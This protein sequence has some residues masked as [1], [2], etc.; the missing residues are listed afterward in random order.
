MK[1]I[2]KIGLCV[3]IGSSA[4]LSGADQMHR[5]DVKSGKVDYEI[6]G[7]GNVMG[8]AQIKTVGKKRIVFDDYGAKSLEEKVEAKKETVMGKTKTTK[9]HT[10]IYMDGDVLYRVDFNKKSIIKTTNP[11]KVMLNAMDKGKS[12]KKAG[13]EMMKSMGGKKTGTDKVLGYTCDVWEVM[14]TKQCIYKGVTLRLEADVMGIKQA[15]VAT[16]AEF[17]ISTGADTFKLPD[18]PVTDLASGSSETTMDAKQ[19]EQTMKAA[20]AL[21][22]MMQEMSKGSN[23]KAPSQEQVGAAIQ[24]A[25]LPMA[26]QQILSQE[27]PLKRLKNCLEDAATR[28]AA[29]QCSDTMAQDTGD[30]PEPIMAWDS[31]TKEQTL[32]EIDEGLAAMRCVKEAKTAKALDACMQ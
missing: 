13:M 19:A 25:M 1:I 2:V 16:K 6:K 15:E 9:T 22:A 29:Q 14:G 8:M 3:V 26:K 24:N 4:L 32:K 23:G 20:A 7:N 10:L 12:A 28:S 30:S 5:Y 17:D 31:Q 21:G 11:A 18:F 27:A